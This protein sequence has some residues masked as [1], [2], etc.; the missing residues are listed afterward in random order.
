[1]NQNWWFDQIGCG[2]SKVCEA[3]VGPSHWL[4]LIMVFQEEHL[5]E[6]GII[7][8]EKLDVIEFDVANVAFCIREALDCG[9]HALSQGDFIKSNVGYCPLSI[10]TNCS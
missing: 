10:V 8:L 5:Y 9:S 7:D 1:M 3:N 6:D 2:A 4:R